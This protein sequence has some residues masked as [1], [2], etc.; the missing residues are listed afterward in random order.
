MITRNFTHSPNP[1]PAERGESFRFHKS[2]LLGVLLFSASLFAHAQFLKSGDIRVYANAMPSSQLNAEMARQYGITRSA[3]RVLLHVVVRKGTPG[4]DKTL[5]AKITAVAIRKNGE[6]SN[7]NMQLTSEGRD[8]YYLGELSISKNEIVNFEII[9]QV[10]RQK[11]MRM[12][13]LQE[14]YSQ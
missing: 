4:K 3:S 1:S 13:F 12:T 6:R 11:P 10:E 8:I 14:F 9:A 2:I 5:P 7:I